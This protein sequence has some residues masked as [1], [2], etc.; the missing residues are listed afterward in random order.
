MDISIRPYESSD[1]ESVTLIWHEGWESTGVSALVPLEKH[2]DLET[3]RERLPQEIA[4]GWAVYVACADG[5]VVGFVA[6]TAGHL[7]QLFVVPALQSQGIG[8]HLLN[9]AKAQQPDGFTL[10]TPTAG[11]AVKFYRREGL[12]AE[13]TSLHPRYGHERVHFRWTRS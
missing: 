5:R 12:V 13:G 11:R 8:A 7:H 10:T 4:G 3:L 2:V 1:F 9:F 6:L